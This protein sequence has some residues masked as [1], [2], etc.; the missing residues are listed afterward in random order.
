MIRRLCLLHEKN[1]FLYHF[2]RGFR[3]FGEEGEL[4]LLPPSAKGDG[5]PGTDA[6]QRA[7]ALADFNGDGAVDLAVAFSDGTV[8]C[9]YND[10]FNKPMLRVRPT[11]H[12]LG[13]VTVSVWQGD[14]V[15]VCVGAATVSGR[16]LPVVFTLGN[17]FPCTLRWSEPGRPSCVKNV[18]SATGESGAVA[19][20]VLEP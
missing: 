19:D 7:C 5:S 14:K 3:C 13:P 16:G 15:P 12:D 8:V 9:H 6:G 17:E 20:V 11:R 1:E 18:V 2:N 4:R 10:A